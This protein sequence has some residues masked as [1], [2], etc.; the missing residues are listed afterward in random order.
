MLVPHLPSHDA[1]VVGTI[2]NGNG[3]SVIHKIGQLLSVVFIGRSEAQGADTAAVV[4]CQM[5]LK[6]KVPALPILAKGSNTP[7]CSMPVCSH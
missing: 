2:A 4:N 5:E 1:S 3:G 6:A 7:R